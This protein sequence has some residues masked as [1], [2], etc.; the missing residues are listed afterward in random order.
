MLI[1]YYVYVNS[2]YIICR[3]EIVKALDNGMY[4]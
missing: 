3:G 2:L 1:Q 4:D